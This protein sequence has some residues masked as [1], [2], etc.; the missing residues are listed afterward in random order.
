MCGVEDRGRPCAAVLSSP[1]E[2]VTGGG[3]M[4]GFLAVAAVPGSGRLYGARWTIVPRRTRGL[5]RAA[6]AARRCRRLPGSQRGG[7]RRPGRRRHRPGSA[8]RRA[9]MVVIARSRPRR[10]PR[11]PRRH[12][13]AG[14]DRAGAER[15]H[16]R[17]HQRARHRHVARDRDDP[18]PDQRAARP[19][20]LHGRPDRQEGRPPGRDRFAPLPAR[21]RP[22]AR[23][24]S[25][26]TRRCCRPPSS[27]SS[28]TR[29]W[30]KTNAIPRQQLDTQQ[31]RWCC[32][33][34]AT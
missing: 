19:R 22:G 3:P 13:A 7:E 33:T 24:R 1:P 30:R 15:R 11:R 12:R 17:D 34:R 16:Q 20:R 14:R 9:G 5:A 28:A 21:A 8:R 18:E 2:A 31:A 23:A 10:A 4:D 32:R 6:D 29:T 25:S 27:T 26:A